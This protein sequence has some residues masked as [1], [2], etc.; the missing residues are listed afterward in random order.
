MSCPDMNFVDRLGACSLG[1]FCAL[2]TRV[3]SSE[4]VD[5]RLRSQDHV[6]VECTGT[7]V[8]VPAEVWF[9]KAKRVPHAQ[10]VET[11]VQ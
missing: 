1:P 6:V 9:T 8:A 11:W 5:C 10:Q 2:R 3:L 7:A 4:G